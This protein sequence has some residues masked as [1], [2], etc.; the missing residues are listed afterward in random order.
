MALSYLPLSTII[1]IVLTAAVLCFPEV[2]RFRATGF[3]FQELQCLSNAQSIVVIVFIM[4]A[5]ATEMRVPSHLF[6]GDREG[7]CCTDRP[8]NVKSSIETLGMTLERLIPLHELHVVH[9][10]TD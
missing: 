2:L 10:W 3:V 4:R 1:C 7:K 9:I 8:K 6:V 5:L